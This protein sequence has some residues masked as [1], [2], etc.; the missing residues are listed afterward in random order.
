MDSHAAA[1]S[2][3]RMRQRVAASALGS[4]LLFSSVTT[5]ASAQAPGTGVKPRGITL[6]MPLEHVRASGGVPTLVG[7]SSRYFAGPGQPPLPVFLNRNGGRYTPGRDDSRANTS[8]V[9]NGPSNVTAFSGSQAQWTQIVNCVRAQFAPFNAVIVETEPT[10]GEY[11]EAVIGGRPGQLGLPNGVGGVAPIDSFQ[12]N[13]IP[14][15]IVFAFSDVY[16]N[17]PQDVCETAAQEIAHAISLDHEL[18]CPDPMTYLSGCGPKSFRDVDAQCGEYQPRACNCG[19]PRQNSVNVLIEKL[20]ASNGANPPPPP[21]NDPT[22]PVVTI[23]SPA[24]GA[25]LPNNTTITITAD[26]TDNIAIAATEL[27]WPFSN[28]VF[29]C[30]TNVNGGNVTCTR[31]GNTSTWRLN[32]GQGDRRFSVRAR[33]TAGNQTVTPERTIRLGQ[34]G[35]PPPPADT[36]P[37][38][39]AITSP[40]DGAMLPGSRTIQVVATAQDNV[41]LGS[42]ELV[43]AYGGDSFPCP[44]SGQGVSCAVNGDTYTWSLNVGL[45]QRQF[46]VRAIDTAG[47]AANTPDVTIQLTTEPTQPPPTPGPDTVAEDNDNA[48]EAFPSRCGNA[49]DLVVANN[50]EDWFSYDAPNGTVVEL[51]VSA[52]AGTVIGVELFADDGMARIANTA[53]VLAGGGTLSATSLGPRILARITTPATSAPYRLSAVCSAPNPPTMEPPTMMPPTMEPPTMEP[54]TNPATGNSPFVRR[55]SGGCACGTTT[56]AGADMTL[57]LAAV[58]AALMLRRR[59]RS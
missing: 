49:I 38:T 56:D 14:N 55:L 34:P 39:V 11:I 45:G 59:R 54:P 2:D 30:P 7:R 4:V 27:V 23:T 1:A 25:T 28:T 36:T 3:G 58:G 16:A 10:G 6:E 41:A 13:I 5:A 24:D 29:A 40:S 9:P 44:S 47:N 42:V 21:P 8:I 35:Q 31:S 17:D 12:C 19:R 22:P 48:G 50:D 51:G 15:A 37:P 52:A 18:H 32:V 20:G 33:D 26:A 46:S 43:W 53:D 57:V